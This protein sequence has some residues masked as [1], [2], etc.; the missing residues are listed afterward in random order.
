MPWRVL[1]AR[2]LSYFIRL[3]NLLFGAVV[4]LLHI[5]D[6]VAVRLPDVRSN[7]ARLQ[8]VDVPFDHLLFVLV[9]LLHGCLQQTCCE[10]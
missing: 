4:S 2:C 7:V 1:L 8:L 6:L 9:D 10:P 3:L 5:L